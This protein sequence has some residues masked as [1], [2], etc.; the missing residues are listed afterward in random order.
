ME[1]AVIDI[2]TTG[3]D[4]DADK[5]VEIGVVRQDGSYAHSLVN[6][7]RKI[8]FGAMGTHHIT[9][10]MVEGAPS[11]D[12][13]LIEVGLN[14]LAGVVPVF[15]NAPF[16]RA[17]LPESISSL[18]Y[19]CTLKCA[20][21]IWPRAESFKNGSLWYEYTDRHD[22]P[23][24]AGEM[25]H[26]ALFDSFMTKDILKAMLKMHSL[27]EL[28]QMTMQPV[29]LIT[30]SFGKHKDTEWADVPSDYMHWVLRQDFD[31]DVIHT[32]KH[33]LEQRQPG[34]SEL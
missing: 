6:P 1:Y 28:M 9:E 16:D 31:E 4:T 17:F 19:I 7:D 3:Q 22:M 14:F 24:E 20:R 23:V 34:R 29:L 13:A 27:E 5:I 32:C 18:P 30:C 26:R 33:H 8:S 21:H 10:H 15:H 2:E 11:L 12:E 25:P